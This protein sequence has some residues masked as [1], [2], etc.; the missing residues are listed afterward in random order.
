MYE[1][2]KR[3]VQWGDIWEIKGKSDGSGHEKGHE[4]VMNFWITCLVDTLKILDGNKCKRLAGQKLPFNFDRI[5][6]LKS[7]PIAGLRHQPP[8]KCFSGVCPIQSVQLVRF[9]RR[10]YLRRRILMRYEKRYLAEMS[11][12]GSKTEAFVCLFDQW[13]LTSAYSISKS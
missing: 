7:Y 5:F 13:K 9:Q 1:Q 8:E 11:I 6:K 4:K 12:L 2:R 3:N 10:R